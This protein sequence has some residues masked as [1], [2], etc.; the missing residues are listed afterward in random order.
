M[1]TL[2]S[3]IRTG[4]ATTAYT[5]IM[6]IKNRSEEERKQEASTAAKILRSPY[7]SKEAKAAAVSV[8]IRPDKLAK[9]SGK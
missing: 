2:G 5:F 3:E 9:R 7:S 6:A 1:Y 8:L 4:L